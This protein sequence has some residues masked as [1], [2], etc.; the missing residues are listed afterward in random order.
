MRKSFYITILLLCSAFF[1]PD[2]NAQ[3]PSR[4][5][6]QAQQ[7]NNKSSMTVRA[8]TQYAPAAEI[9][10]DLKWKRE[11]YRTIDLTEENNSSLYYPERPVGNEMNLFTLV[12][13]LALANRIPVFEYT[14]DG[15]E[16]FTKS[17][18]LNP[19]DMLD[20]YHIYYEERE[21][22]NDTVFVVDDADVPSNE[23]KSYFVKEVNYFNDRSS[24]YNKQVE[25]FCPVLHRADEFTGEETKYP[26]FWVRYKDVAPYLSRTYVM[27]SDYNN[28]T[29][30]TLNDFFITGMYKGD[31]YKTTNRLNKTL[32]QYCP[33]DSLMK[34]EQERIENQLLTFEENLW[35]APD[36]PESE[37]E[38]TEESTGVKEKRDNS[39]RIGRDRQDGNDDEEQ[40][41]DDDSDKNDNDNK[42][43]DKVKKE[44]TKK[45]KSST[46][47]KKASSAPRAT[48]RRTRR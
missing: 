29:S 15:I 31:I 16:Q 21:V 18:R 8:R 47:T 20:R 30:I 9:P 19:R 33:T 4:R 14:L 34:A 24:T 44:K 46:K 41:K 38:E 40:M 32:A 43:A 17:N 22:R 26:M 36:A 2:A 7:E 10:E 28:V 48:V 45:V 42:D 1:M 23:V 39:K 13:K 35:K 12:F 27:T 11:I 5:R 25:A 3:A 37:Q 6:Q